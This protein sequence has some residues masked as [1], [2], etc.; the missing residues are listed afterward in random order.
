MMVEKITQL[1][2]LGLLQIYVTQPLHNNPTIPPL[3][4]HCPTLHRSSSKPFHPSSN[5]PGFLLSPSWLRSLPHILQKKIQDIH[6]ELPLLPSSLTPITQVSSATLSSFISSHI[7]R[8]PYSLP[9][10]TPLFVQEIPFH[11]IS[12]T[13]CPLYHSY[14]ITYC[15]PVYSLLPTDM[16]MSHLSWIKPLPDPSILDNY[17]PVSLLSFV[18]KLPEKSIFNRYLHPPLTIWL[19][20]S[21]FNWNFSLQNY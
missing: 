17:S 2:W 20:S 8:W 7:M 14:I 16:S 12:F 9:S 18:A 1:F 10:L 19:L 21:L 15:L 6:C 13:D 3:L 11:L 5:L 4:P